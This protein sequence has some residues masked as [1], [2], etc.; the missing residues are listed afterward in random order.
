M[1]IGQAFVELL[2]KVNCHITYRITYWTG[3]H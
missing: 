1:Q 2:Q 3:L